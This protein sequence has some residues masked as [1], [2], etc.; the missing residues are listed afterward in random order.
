ML[1]T[2]KMHYV[3][4]GITTIISLFLLVGVECSNSRSRTILIV[5]ASSLT[6]AFSDMGMVFEREYKPSNVSVSFNFV[7]SA[8]GA[9]QIEQGLPAC[10]FASAD[11]HQMQRLMDLDFTEDTKTFAYNTLSI[12]VNN[13]N[14]TIKQFSDIASDKGTILVVASRGVPAGEYA[15]S[16]LRS[17]QESG[18]YANDFY[19]RVT[20]NIKSEELNV[21]AALV[22]VQTGQA[23][24]AIVYKTD[25]VSAGSSVKEL[26]IPEEY[27]QN[28]QYV[29]AVLKNCDNPYASEFFKFVNSQQGKEILEKHSFIPS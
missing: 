21:R 10:I 9:T 5:A 1:E 7:S 27:N 6:D 2:V 15:H 3:L 22:K 24:A 16:M 18:R 29:I 13:D 28:A 20:A 23:D 8:T 11:I 14:V 4:L 12:A 19:K 25:I 26:P 17:A